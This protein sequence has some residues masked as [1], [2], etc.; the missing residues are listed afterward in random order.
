MC[1]TAYKPT[2]KKTG[3]GYKVFGISK[4]QLTSE[5][6]GGV[7]PARKWLK[8][9]GGNFSY[10][11]GFHIFTSRKSAVEWALIHLTIR[12]VKYRGAF[13]VGK[14]GSFNCV[15]A[16]EIYIFRGAK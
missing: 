12:R 4:G 5:F 2:K 7:R 15:V 10:G 1:I 14:Q 11:A 3:V 6:Y 16:K 13:L 9:D 8:A